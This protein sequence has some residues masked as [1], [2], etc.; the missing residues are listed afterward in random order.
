MLL[1]DQRDLADVVARLTH[2]GRAAITPEDLRVLTALARSEPGRRL[3]RELG[4]QIAA[5]AG[6]FDAARSV[7]EGARLLLRAVMPDRADRVTAG[8]S[9]RLI[10][11]RPD[12]RVDPYGRRRP[13]S[14]SR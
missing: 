1:I 11:P 5:M 14:R 9:T 7:P 2:D 3:D 13:T 12:G 10:A 8:S 4:R 6:T